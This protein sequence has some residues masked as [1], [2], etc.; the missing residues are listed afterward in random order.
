M[1]KRFTTVCLISTALT[2][3]PAMAQS[4]SANTAQNTQEFVTKAAVGGMF[5]I[6]SSQLALQKSQD[7]SIRAFA[8]KMIDDHTKADDQLK[9]VAKGEKVPTSLDQQHE[10]MLK[11]LQADTGSH[12]TE[13]F[14]QMQ[15]L[16]H[17]QTIDVFQSYA[18]HGGNRQI[19]Q[20]AEQTLPT[21]KQH[22]QMA[23]HIT[24]ANSANGSEQS[25]AGTH[26]T[27]NSGGREFISTEQPGIWRAS[28][29]IGVNVY[30]EQN[31][32]VGDINEV[33]FDRSGKAEGVVIGVGGFLGIG[34]R[35][36]AVPYDQLKWSM[37]PV[38]SGSNTNG[39]TSVGNTS[40]GNN[41]AAPTPS[42][43]G[44]PASPVNPAPTA[45]AGVSS[46]TGMGTISGT[47]M[48]ARNPRSAAYPDH[49]ILANAS[50]DQ[51]QNA[52]QFQYGG[53]PR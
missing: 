32:K 46:A 6:Q 5:E 16:A 8:Q 22:L 29:M 4:N 41:A 10:Q 50:K 43:L 3:L 11:I 13:Q 24:M 34:E 37:T 36:V 35:N 25:S 20:F 18:E 52:P 28:K 14:K 47:P 15:V 23:Q 33:L 31:Q 51:L 26:V 19:K 1:I 21:L 2:A 48:Q 40:A 44:G 27:Q 12:F 7:Q 17:Q 49:A 38:N 45:N 42:P 30:N 9:S 39:N 53:S